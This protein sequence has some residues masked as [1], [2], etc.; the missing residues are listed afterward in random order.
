VSVSELDTIVSEITIAADPAT[1]FAFFTE[2]DLY[3]RW[4]GSQARLEPW[5]GGMYAID[6]NEAVRAR[7]SFVELVPHS[8]IVF[9]FGWEGAGQPVPPGAST[10][11]VTLTPTADGTHVRLVHRG[12]LQIEAR[13][14]HLHGWQLYLS[15]LQ[16]VAGGGA[17][18][19]DPNANPSPGG[20]N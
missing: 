5:P 7:G 20:M 1:V 3:A 17:A 9:T 14:Q 12:L 10:V 13:E 4:M 18:G 19:P 15:R 8:R 2:A 6:I 16:I 11:E